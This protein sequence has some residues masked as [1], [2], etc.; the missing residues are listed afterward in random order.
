MY[1][2]GCL[3]TKHRALGMYLLCIND[4]QREHRQNN[5]ASSLAFSFPLLSFPAR[6]V[7]SPETLV[8]CRHAAG[9]VLSEGSS[10]GQASL[11]SGRPGDLLLQVSAL[12]VKNLGLPFSTVSLLLAALMS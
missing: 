7:T 11:D 1:R 5:D 4:Q 12:L 10:P 2:C 8:F 9:H 3:R 6:E